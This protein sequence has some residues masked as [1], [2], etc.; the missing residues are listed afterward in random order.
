MHVTIIRSKCVL[1]R[2][3][4]FHYCYLPELLNGIKNAAMYILVNITINVGKIS[5]HDSFH[6]GYITITPRIPMLQ[7]SETYKKRNCILYIW[8]A[9][10]GG[11]V[12]LRHITNALLDFNLW[13]FTTQ[14]GRIERRLSFRFF[15]GF[16]S[17]PH[18]LVFLQ[19]V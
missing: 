13:H 11:L 18:R 19:I 16:K 10:R 5:L 9:M 15:L 8:S 1:K 2:P 12:L 14:R 3:S 6:F 4:M 7:K 17:C